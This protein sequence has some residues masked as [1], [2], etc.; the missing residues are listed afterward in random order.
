MAASQFRRGCKP[1]RGHAI[2]R[3]GFQSLATC[4]VSPHW[5]ARLGCRNARPYGFYCAEL[6]QLKAGQAK[7]PLKPQWPDRAGVH[8][9]SFE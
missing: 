5:L 3:S 7:N 1:D 9:R 4:G 2:S 6:S 8:P